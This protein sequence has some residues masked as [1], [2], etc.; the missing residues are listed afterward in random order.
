MITMDTKD[1]ST[2]DFELLRLRFEKKI[3][4]IEYLTAQGIAMGQL[5]LITWEEYIQQVIDSRGEAA[6]TK[7]NR[8]DKN[9]PKG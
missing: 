7:Q 3:N 1:L 5:G 6:E 2:I 9:K 8:Q 4:I